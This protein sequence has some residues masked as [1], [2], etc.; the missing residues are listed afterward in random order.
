MDY[1]S[2]FYKKKYDDGYG[3]NFYTQKGGFYDCAKGPEGTYPDHCAKMS[4]GISKPITYSGSNFLNGGSLFNDRKKK[5]SS[6]GG[7]GGAVVGL[8]VTVIIIGVIAFAIYWMWKN[9]KF[10]FVGRAL[11]KAEMQQKNI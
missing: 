2:P 6:S 1:Y 5:E 3:W 8:I 4:S 10:C 9:R 11:T 7:G